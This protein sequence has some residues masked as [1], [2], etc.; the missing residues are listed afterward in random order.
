MHG[1]ADDGL[2]LGFFTQQQANTFLEEGDIDPRRLFYDGGRAFLNKQS[3]NS[4]KSLPLD[5]QLLKAATFVCF[6]QRAT[7]DSLHAEYRINRLAIIDTRVL[8]TLS[9]VFLPTRICP[10]HLILAE[11]F[12]HY[13]LLREKDILQI[14]WDKAKVEDGDKHCHVDI[15][16]HYFSTL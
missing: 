7:A 10:S 13:Q 5:D 9:I 2:Q 14:V 11:G 1:Y 6:D 12:V 16:W 3:T 4:L 8:F 15:L